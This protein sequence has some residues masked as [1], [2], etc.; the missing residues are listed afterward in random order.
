VNLV[1]ITEAEAA[2]GL[3]LGDARTTHLL[4]T[5]GIKVGQTF[6]VGI[7]DGLRGL[8]TVTATAP[9]LRFT[10]AWEKSVQPRLPLTVLVGL[11]RPQTA[12]KVLHDLAS[13]GAARLVFFEADKGDPGYLASSLWKD[14]EY[15]E[16]VRKGTEQA[17]STLVP[18]VVRVSSL[19]DALALAVD[20]GWKVSLDPYE[21]SG[22]LGEVGAPGNVKS[23]ALAI[24]PERG[25][26][27]RERSAL[28]AAGFTAH[29][30]GDRIL[31]VEAAALVGGALLL[32]QLRVW[33]PHQALG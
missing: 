24:G 17:C 20:A 15:V 16:H 25:W 12:K 23:A 31:R 29:H 26:S 6:H 18:E 27:D 5:V 8:A 11:P 1:L 2:A 30:L 7:V 19:A 32:G 33:R 3:P 9:A 13:L 22:A 14:G 28:R 10:V 4:G 21:T